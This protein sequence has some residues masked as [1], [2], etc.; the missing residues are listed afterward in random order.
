ML[1]KSCGARV[2]GEGFSTNFKS[3]VE[4]QCNLKKYD[5][6]SN[7]DFLKRHNIDLIE[8]WIPKFLPIEGKFMRNLSHTD[9][10][11]ENQL[12]LEIYMRKESRLM[13]VNLGDCQGHIS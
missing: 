6:Q 11:L 10:I 12:C 13:C 9:D 5:R 7:N 8:V 3:P 1:E 4:N 2:I